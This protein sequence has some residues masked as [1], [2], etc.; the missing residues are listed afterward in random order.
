M[1]A[2]AITSFS[3]W[4]G[5]YD[6]IRILTVA[7]SF[8]CKIGLNAYTKNRDNSRHGKMRSGT[9][10][11][12]LVRDLYYGQSTIKNQF[13]DGASRSCRTRINGVLWISNVSL[14]G[15]MLPIHT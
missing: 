1:A 6:I 13:S 5:L 4:T 2:V 8:A 15:H 11:K 10:R 12:I 9:V 7:L 3:D 14:E